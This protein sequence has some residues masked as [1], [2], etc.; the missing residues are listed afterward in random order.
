MRQPSQDSFRPVGWWCC[1]STR[2]VKFYASVFL[3]ILWNLSVKKKEKRKKNPN[4][5]VITNPSFLGP[6]SF[7]AMVEKQNQ[8]M[9]K[10][11]GWWSWKR[12]ETGTKRTRAA[13]LPEWLR[14]T[15]CETGSVKA[16]PEFRVAV[17]RALAEVKAELKNRRCILFTTEGG[18]YV[19]IKLQ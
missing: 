17:Q 6:I 19:M 4:K 11:G 9:I 14:S 7:F 8:R 18:D 2:Q 16:E 1:M 10:E 15:L 13:D 12:L 3:E 5:S